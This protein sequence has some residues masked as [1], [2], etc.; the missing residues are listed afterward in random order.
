MCLTHL[1]RVGGLQG[2]RRSSSWCC[3]RK[4]T[5]AWCGC[6]ANTLTT[7]GGCL[8]RNASESC[9]GATQRT[10][11][12]CFKTLLLSRWRLR[13]CHFPVWRPGLNL[14]NLIVLNRIKAP[15]NR[16]ILKPIGRVW[17]RRMTM[18]WTF[19]WM[20][21]PTVTPNYH[22]IQRHG[23][24]LRTGSR[25]TLPRKPFPWIFLTGPRVLTVLLM[26]RLTKPTSS[27]FSVHF[28]Q[29]RTVGRWQRSAQPAWRPAGRKVD[30]SHFW[31]RPWGQDCKGH[32]DPV[33]FI[34]NTHIYIY[35]YY[36]L[37]LSFFLSLF[38][39]RTVHLCC[40]Y[41]YMYTHV[42]M[43]VCATYRYMR[44]I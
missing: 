38:L 24:Q 23:L 15:Q 40:M 12:G 29:W 27:L 22:L 5:S 32:L 31:L 18:T 20:S 41:V 16:V 17:A 3:A 28:W 9:R 36:I 34:Y 39:S 14:A 43:C 33:L 13:G 6:L 4:G 25:K 35:M 19:S 11:R 21:S 1:A 10:A 8:Y 30:G 7:T 37:F 2:G 26:Q 44:H 42:Y